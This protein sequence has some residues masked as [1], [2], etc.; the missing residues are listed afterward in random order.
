MI[1]KKFFSSR[2]KAVLFLIKYFGKKANLPLSPVCVFDQSQRFPL[3]K[4]TRWFVGTLDEF[5]A[6]H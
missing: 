3:R 4:K 6:I 2:K 5:L 1:R